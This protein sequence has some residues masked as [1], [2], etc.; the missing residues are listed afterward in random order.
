MH[1]GVYS[2]LHLC[3]CMYMH[4]CVLRIC[5]CLGHKS[6]SGML[7]HSP[8]FKDSGSLLNPELAHFSFSRQPSCL[9]D[10][11]FLPPKLGEYRQAACL[12]R[13]YVDAEIKTPGH[14]LS[15]QAL[16]PLNHLSSSLFFFYPL[17]FLRNYHLYYQFI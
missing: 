2:C 7:S 17:F 4:G 1:V 3:V 8:L 12:S 15:Q 11:L 10:P 5:M 14:S 6:V 9:K 13:F 16:C